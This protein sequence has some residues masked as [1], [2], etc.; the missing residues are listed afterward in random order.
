MKHTY[1]VFQTRL[2]SQH[3]HKEIKLIITIILYSYSKYTIEYNSHHTTKQNLYI[4][5]FQ[6]THI[7]SNIELQKGMHRM[8]EIIR[9]TDIFREL[10]INAK[11]LTMHTFKHV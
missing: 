7:F 1:G 11:T 4:N 10:H 5:K 9:K 6:F 8:G 3:I 2:G